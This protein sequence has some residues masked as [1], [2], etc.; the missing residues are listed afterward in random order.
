MKNVQQLHEKAMDLAEMALVA[1]LKGESQRANQLFRQAYENE[2]QAA[3]LMLDKSAPEP[4]RSILYRSAASLALDCKKFREAEKLIGA[5]LA[6]N[7][8]EEIAEELRELYEKAIFYRHLASRG[9]SLESDELLMSLAGRAIGFGIAAIGEFTRRLDDVQRLLR[10]TVDR[11]MDKPY[12]EGGI[13]GGLARDF[14]FFV[15]GLE[16]GSFVVSLKVGSPNKQL[17][18]PLPNLATNQI[19]DEILTCLELFNASKE[20]EL[21]DKIPTPSYYRNFVGIAR[22]I[23]PDGDEV[24]VVGFTTSRR[25]VELTK[26]RDEIG[27]S[28]DVELAEDIDTET[29][30]DITGTLK[31]A[32]ATHSEK[33]TIRLIDENGK[34][35]YIIVPEGMM[36][37]IVKPLWDEIV[38]VTGLHRGKEIQLEN[39]RRANIV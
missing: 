25:T 33:Q 12:S 9:V 32:D 1:K 31:Y 27:L 10:R 2:A 11:I 5:G 34:T 23:A 39:I 3:N 35:Y 19:V 29:K 22:S 24:N 8:P 7:P 13:A 4:T 38:T 20:I 17:L 15:S 6:G 21:R 36:S 26:P 16:P 18:L 30:I 14:V 37:D 28:L